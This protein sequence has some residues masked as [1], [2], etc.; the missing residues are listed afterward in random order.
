MGNKKVT[1][2]FEGNQIQASEG[3]TIAEALLLNGVKEFGRNHKGYSRG[4]FCLMG[5]CGQ[6]FVK[7]DDQI[8]VKTCAFRVS[9]EMKIYRQHDDELSERDNEV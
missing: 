7:V 8:N 3:Q 1:L 9:P 6:C 5:I 4:P 2:F